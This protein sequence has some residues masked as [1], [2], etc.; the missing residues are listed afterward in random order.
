MRNRFSKSICVVFGIVLLNS[1]GTSAQMIDLN[2]NGMSD[3]WESMFNAQGIDPNADSDG[4]GL[5][6]L[7]ESIAATDPFDS[8]SIPKI[9][10]S[11]TSRTNITVA[12]PNAPGKLYQLQSIPDLASTNWV[13]EASVISQPGGPV[14]LISPTNAGNRFFRMIISDVDSDGDGINDWEKYMLGLSPTNAFSNGQL[15]SLGQPMTDFAYATNKL[16]SQNVI[17]IR[18][19]NPTAQQPDPNQTPL[20]YGTY[21]V[22]RGGFP[23]NAIT[24]NLG[25][26]GPGVGFA[27]SNVDYVALPTNVTLLAGVS[28]QD[29]TLIPMADTNLVTPAIAMLKIMPGP[30][31]SL[32][33]AT[34]AS[35]VIY[36]SPTPVG[37]GLLGQYFTNSHLVYLS[38]TNFN[39]TNLFLTRI[40]SA[41]DFVWTN[42]TSP[43]LSNGLYSVRWTGQ[44]QPQYSENYYFDVKSD[45]GVKLWVND[46]LL[47]DKWQAQNSEY[48]NNIALQGG[49]RYDLKLEYL[50]HGTTAQAHLYWFSAIQ[51]KQV[52]PSSCL[53]PT[54]NFGNTS[55]AP[56]VVTSSLNAV[57]Y[58]DQPFSFTL[59]GANTTLGF[60]AKGLP[61]GLSLTGSIISGTPTLVGEY[62]VTLTAT[63]AVGSGASVLDIT[64]FDTGSA[65]TRE[66]WT[67]VPGINISNIPVN[68]TPNS[69]AA[70]GA[71][72][73]ITDYGDNYGERIRG[74]LTPPA[75]GNYYFWVAGSDSVELW[76]S[77]DSEPVNKVRRAWVSPTNNPTAPPNNGTGS[78]QWNVQSTQRSPWIS[79]VAGQKY[80]IEVL[81]KADTGTGDNWAVGWSLDAL[82]TNTV[83]DSVVPGYVL[84]RYFDLPP[85]YVPGT[86]YT[87]NMLA[88]GTT[89]SSGVGSAT[90][91]LSADGTQAVLRRTFSG[92]TSSL[93]GEHIHSDL[94][95]DRN[96]QGQIIFDIDQTPPQPDGSYVWNIA[97]IG[98]LSAADIV[99]IIK[100][101]KAYIN[102]HTV[103][104]PGGEINGHF[105][106]A[107]GSQ[108]FT[109]PPAPIAWTDDHTSSN[110]AARFL[111]QSTFGPG[112][113]DITNVQSLGYNSWIDNQFALPVTHH[114][115]TVLA[116]VSASSA[117]LYPSSLLYN[118]WWQQSVTAPDQLRQRVA[119]AL[120]EIMVSSQNGVLQDNATALSY[121]YDALLDNSFGN[122][123]DLLKSVTLTP[124]MGLYLDM[125]RNDKGDITL[126]THANENYAR[127]IMQL[128]S[129]GLNRLW[130]DGTLV[131][132][133]QGN[134]VPTYDQSVISGM[135]ADF[136][137]WNYYQTNLS[138]GHLPS[139]WNPSANYT[140]QMVMVS[141]HHDLGT[142]RLLDNVMLPAAQG[143]QLASTNF[144]YDAYATQDLEKA[145]DSI[146]YNEN[147]GPFICRQLIQRLVT[148]NPSRDY[149]YRVVQKF[150][151]D[152]NG[153]RGNMQAVIKAI[154][155]DYE[156]RS[157]NVLALPTYG[158]QR[159]PVLRVTAPARAFLAPPSVSG[160]YSESGSR[161]I[162]I[163]TTPTPNRVGTN[164]TVYLSFTDT[165]GHAAPTPQGYTA[166][167]ISATM[168]SVNAAGM[169]T[170]TY[171][172]AGNVITVTNSAHGLVPNDFVNIWFN[173]GGAI[174]TNYQVVTVPAFTNNI[175]TVTALDSATRGGTCIIPKWTGG[176]YVQVTNGILVSVAGIH[177]LN[178]GDPVFIDFPAGAI[179]SNGVYQVTSVPDA[180]HFYI[181]STNFG[182]RTDNSPLIYPLVAPQLSRSGT[183]TI[184]E[185]TWNM[186][187]TDTGTSSSL[188]QSPMNSPTVFNFFF[189]DYRSPGILASAGLTT[190]EFQL[191]SDTGVIL[192]MN[193][194][195]N[196]VLNNTGNTNG[197]SS[198]ASGNG[199][200][201]LDLSPWMTTNYTSDIGI[202][203][204]VE[205]LNTVLLAGQLSARAKTN[206]TAFAGSTVNFPYSSPP[207]PMQMRDR[208]RAVVHLILSSPDYTIQK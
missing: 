186:G 59:G 203:N 157:T 106:L 28:S 66:V 137:G 11:R 101:G 168:F 164:D 7:K 6:N 126:G 15:D 44:V 97:A 21:T 70:F 178:T 45:D 73:G 107:E 177:G 40:D 50:Q 166:T 38:N 114:L 34:N 169:T 62:Q 104:Y 57:A 144:E 83:P 84:S 173:T 152:G 49:V 190:P 153:V 201:V 179:S 69:S 32:S 143:L 127:E 185:N 63:N 148:S 161:T 16:G 95:L 29:I 150:D 76:I 5:S 22:S 64:V 171:S 156:A 9:S 54:N 176:G 100:E 124:A 197:L 30:N 48:S 128:F 146:F 123:R 88:Q 47:L 116:N 154:L 206:I 39:P 195:E 8:N 113:S 23:L 192:Q 138:N 142:K 108:R 52:I 78:R 86:L 140:N 175:F 67:G 189:P 121:Y 199:A 93:T 103:N 18:A 174:S 56:A 135:A 98:T 132:N 31:Y 72:E 60:T 188:M 24:V 96:N 205:N 160:T 182:T 162:T 208:V 180:T 53:Y 159:E 134:I 145:L 25:L 65:V 58:L 147:V 26:G 61:P 12:T 94:Y 10:I 163:D 200:I 77:D 1:G 170:G 17:T 165:S 130:P 68:L 2:T 102:I 20:D 42:G 120:S 196:G 13:T 36:P 35:V 187:A 141:T 74:Y 129:I 51:S 131:L 79:L 184:K 92:L 122:F 133:S 183:V 105:S 202:S 80:Y 14:N 90:L 117:T 172:Q 119:F 85:S 4:D 125:R 155:L 91:R 139:N 167:V 181:V 71:L 19:S 115:P 149:L 55:N 118:T 110:A 81:H 136:T 198:F 41:I 46:Q 158:K 27:V 43:N 193:F 89:V 99:E 82:G 87:A 151:D 111:I 37:T 3:V 33:S 207:T 204:L 112:P 109:P 75:T 194:L 191:T